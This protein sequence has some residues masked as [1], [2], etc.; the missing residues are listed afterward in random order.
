MY[1]VVLAIHNIVRWIALVLAIVAAVR[2]FLGW[3][4]K[5]EW[6]A[7]DRKWGMY[8][9]IAMDTQ[10]LLGL[11][12]YI[13]FSP[14]TKAAL[15]DFGAAMAVQDLRYFAV[16]HAFVMLLALVFA[17]LGS[18]LP[19]RAKEAVAKRRMAAIFFTLTVL[20]ILFGMPWM[21]PLFPGLG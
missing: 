2:A 16:E 8:T 17:H 10:L 11:L 20:F 12:L 9:A 3:F 5:Q 6:T 7:S 14:I 15:Q 13:F 21:R 1:S 19:R 18:M 4:R